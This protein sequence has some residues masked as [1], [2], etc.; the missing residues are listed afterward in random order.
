MRRTLTYFYYD[1]KYILHTL[2]VV[3]YPY[4]FLF[5]ILL[6]YKQKFESFRIIV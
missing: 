2:F 4:L 5:I 3:V 1:S 6:V